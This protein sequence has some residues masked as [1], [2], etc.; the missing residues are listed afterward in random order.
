[1]QDT[2]GRVYAKLSELSKGS[3]VQ[4]DGGFDCMH[5]NEFKTVRQRGNALFV[6]CADGRHHL[7]G[8]LAPDGDSLIGIYH[9]ER[10]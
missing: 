5:P 6:H 10:V 2:K 1:M 7:T 4:V 3:L 9:A 8:Q